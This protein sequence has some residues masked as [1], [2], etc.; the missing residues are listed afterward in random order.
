M[1]FIPAPG[2][3]QSCPQGTAVTLSP[4]PPPARPAPLCQPEKRQARGSGR[5]GGAQRPMGW[6]QPH[7]EGDQRLALTSCTACKEMSARLCYQL[8]QTSVS[9]MTLRRRTRMEEVSF[10]CA[11][12]APA[13]S[14][15]LAYNR[16][17]PTAPSC[18]PTPLPP[19]KSC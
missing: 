4:E 9:R 10:T 2:P 14:F 3:H 12:K 7:P 17:A 5:R 11:Q 6:T 16:T 1:Y 13:I 19:N 15:S 18:P 8:Q